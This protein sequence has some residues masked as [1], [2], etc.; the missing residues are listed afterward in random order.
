MSA[1]QKKSWIEEKETKEDCR[2]LRQTLGHGEKRTSTK[3]KKETTGASVRSSQENSGKGRKDY[4]SNKI[5]LIF[6]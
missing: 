6:F 4:F 1:V 2:G 3:G 5:F